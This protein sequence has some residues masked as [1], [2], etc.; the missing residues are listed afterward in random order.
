MEK[1]IDKNLFPLTSY[2]ILRQMLTELE[3]PQKVSKSTA[4]DYS[5]QATAIKTALSE[6]PKS[7][8][9]QNCLDL[10]TIIRLR[11]RPYFT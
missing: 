8:L 11:L 1:E 3:K 7:D 6:Y 9:K 4:T 2:G 10:V 5:L